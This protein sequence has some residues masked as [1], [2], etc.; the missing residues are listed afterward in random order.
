MQNMDSFEAWCAARQGENVRPGVPDIA[1]LE[2]F[3]APPHLDGRAGVHRCK[4]P[5]RIDV[6]D[7]LA[8]LNWW[9]T[10]SAN[11]P[12]SAISR[13]GAAEKLLNWACFERGK[14]V[15]SLDEEDFAAFARFLSRP[16]P[17]H[18]WVGARQPRVSPAWRPFNHPMIGS[19]RAAVLKQISALVNW[20]STQHYAELRFL[21]GKRPM[22]DG[23]ATT[24][25][26]G[27][28]RQ[29]AP[30][31]PLSVAEW[32]WIRQALDRHF[33]TADLASQRFVVELLYY[34][35]LRAEEIAALEVRHFNPPNRSAP[36]WSIYVRG[37]Q[38]WRGGQRVFAAPPLSE[39]VG[40]WMQQRERPAAG[41]VTFRIRGCAD[42]LLG[43]HAEQ[44]ARQGRQVLRLAASL[45][46]EGGDIENGMRLRGHSV[47]RLRGAFA[48]HQRKQPVDRGAI[49]L[50]SRNLNYGTDIHYRE[51]A[52]W[53]WRLATHLWV[54]T[55]NQAFRET[56][57][58]FDDASWP[59]AQTSGDL[60]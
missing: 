58:V 56:T 45:A 19:S 53:D 51:P 26:Q 27:A 8:A 30:L 9:V 44:V 5:C 14:A 46:L 35:D 24:P 33:P 12:A 52:P 34:G 32:H 15:S 16:E 18:R 57:G 42:A 13:R 21:Y 4:G 50:T 25:V 20:L 59:P 49:E 10:R 38:G 23:C 39:T 11:S 2:R 29:A 54:E 31:E 47:V 6:N 28:E 40:L 60:A 7:D 36:G 1:P 3:V 37:R 22:D 48:A 55:Q 43:L 41:Y 17:L